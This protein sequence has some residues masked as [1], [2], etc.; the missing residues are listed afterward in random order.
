MWY[1]VII[2]NIMVVLYCVQGIWNCFIVFNSIWI[3]WVIGL[4]LVHLQPSNYRDVRT[5]TMTIW[6]A[7]C[8][9]RMIILWNLYIPGIFSNLCCD[10]HNIHDGWYFIRKVNFILDLDTSTFQWCL[11]IENVYLCNSCHNK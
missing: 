6:L 10:I 3:R 1:M 11:R 8:E 9:C 2:I 7:Y 4:L 5:T